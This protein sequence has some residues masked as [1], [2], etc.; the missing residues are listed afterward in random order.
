MKILHV[1]TLAELGGAQSVVINLAHKSIEEGHEVFVASCVDGD[2]WNLLPENA[3]QIKL[4]RLK[5]SIGWRDVLVLNNLRNIYHKIKPDAIHLH[6]SKIG[7]L[8]RL[9]FPKS[10]TIYTV[11]G[12]DSI[13][14]RYRRFL[15]IEKALQNRCKAIVGVSEYDIHNLMNENIK[16]NIHLVRNGIKDFANNFFDFN[17]P[18]LSSMK[19]DNNKIILCISRLAP[20]KRFDL[21]CK[22]A[23]K[24]SE[25]NYQFIWIGNKESADLVPENVHMMGEIKDAHYYY[26][27]ADVALLLSDYEG[28]PIS[29]LEALSYSK[30]II[31]SNV[32]GIPELIENNGILVSNDNLSE[33]VNSIIFILSN[34]KNYEK[35]AKNSREIFED[36]YT[37]E[38]MYDKYIDLY[39]DK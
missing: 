27:Y 38:K 33:I 32:G 8:G 35:F 13:R 15:P 31:A 21:F 36:K 39:L 1:I 12:F 6:S 5:H 16:K 17:D 37:I 20:P 4:K 30:P 7:I 11:H 14:L 10:K 28:L 24:L 26:K 29:L 18:V 34:P 3:I 19:S 22:V 9:V 23:E 2:M 25:L